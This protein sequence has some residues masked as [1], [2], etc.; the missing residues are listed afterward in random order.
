MPEGRVE[1][2]DIRGGRVG[3]RARTG[4]LHGAALDAQD[5]ELVAG[6]PQAGLLRL[7]L[8]LAG[9]GSHYLETGVH[10]S[11][12]VERL[13]EGLRLVYPELESSH[14]SAPIRVE[15][16]LHSAPEG[17]VMSARVHNGADVPIPQV[18]FPQL[19]GLAAVGGS[20][21]ARVGLRASAA[22]HPPR[23]ALTGSDESR[24][25]LSRGTVWPLRQLAMRPDDAS[26]LETPL[27]RYFGY[28]AF[29]F[30]MKWLDYGDS[31]GGLTLYSRD[32]RYAA[33]G[34]L[35]ERPDRSKD[36]VNLRWLHL[37][38]IAPRQTWES[39]DYVLLLHGGDWHAGARAFQEFAADAYPYNA[40]SHI[41]EAL[42]IRTVWPAIRHAPPN[43]TIDEL[44]KY[45]EEI[46]DPD[47]GLAELCVWHWWEKNGLP[48]LMNP[49]LGDEDDMRQALSR[50][51]ELG[52]PV[53]LFVSHHLLR[54]TDESPEEW[55]HL[56]AAGQPVQ[57]DWTYGR[58]FL[59]KF[60]IPFM[61][62]HAMVR[63]SLLAPS[64]REA[65]L[66]E[67]E[68]I[69]GM[70]ATST[71]W[72]QFWAWYEPNYNPS[73]DGAPDEEGDR[74]LD[75]GRA[76]HAL[77]QSKDP[78]GTFSGEMITEQK[79]PMLDYT[80]DWRNAVDLDE[81]AP[82]RYVFPHV[83]LNA[84]VN[85]D[86]RGALLAFA[87][88]GLINVMPGQMNSYR[89]A[90]CPQLLAALRQLAALR[91]RFLRFFCEGQYRH[92]EGLVVTNCHARAYS[93]G[94][95]VLVVVLNPTDDPAVVT[96][97][98]DPTAWGGAPLTG[99]PTV[100]GLDGKPRQGWEDDAFRDTIEPDGLRVLEFVNAGGVQP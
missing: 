75:V 60:H 73:A 45:A 50:C 39:G 80:W 59:P 87:D 7:A 29:E 97:T 30:S 12:E 1:W 85:E 49:R 82:F 93:D 94:D 74:L 5:I 37:A 16:E 61:G 68:R 2:I 65:I 27:Q 26:F 51:R 47:L 96:T 76:L 20:D 86:P 36:E 24:L 84:N 25:R 44:P 66:A 58:D 31:R 38:T 33:Q 15:V 42:G 40:P 10:G 62:T 46:A 72:D 48:I 55:K 88:G 35:V 11:P 64:L 89:L 78:R 70:G 41:R 52:V 6:E 63:G 9:Y 90:D 22:G 18:A 77:V 8:P 14:L 19:L 81:D 95:D 100:V 92:V 17:L 23:I 28:G 43:F 71:C 98:V 83:R 13:P 57:D 91:R 56:N 21:E 69:L 4:A 67:H 32:P 79:V 3:V 53:S 54:D 99:S 34:L